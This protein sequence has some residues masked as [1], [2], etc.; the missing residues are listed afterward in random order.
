[1]SKT[2]SP[3]R[4]IETS[5]WCSPRT[6][7]PCL[8]TRESIS[9]SLFISRKREWSLIR[10][11]KKPTS[12]PWK[13]LALLSRANPWKQEI[14][15][16]S[17]P[18]ARASST[19]SP[20]VSC[21]THSR[22]EWEPPTAA[23]RSYRNYQWVLRTWQ[24]QAAFSTLALLTNKGWWRSQSPTDSATSNCSRRHMSSPNC[25]LK[26][27]ECSLTISV[28]FL[29]SGRRTERRSLTGESFWGQSREVPG[30]KSWKW[31]TPK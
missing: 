2:R 7:L 14:T 18:P 30:K 1:M 23:C 26:K 3:C 9:I 10:F 16:T 20:E 27:E 29:S 12:T 19:T 31:T 25:L 15:P 17:K 11:T 28:I 5:K 13:C 6:I 8:A 21:L 4:S 24:P 22:K